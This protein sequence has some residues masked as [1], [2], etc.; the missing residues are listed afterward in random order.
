MASRAA[1]VSCS[2]NRVLPTGRA[3]LPIIAMGSAGAVRERPSFIVHTLKLSE[4]ALR[5]R[6][7]GRHH[8]TSPP[9]IPTSGSGHY[10]ALDHVAHRWRAR[11]PHTAST[12]DRRLSAR[13]LI[14]MARHAAKSIARRSAAVDAKLKKKPRGE[15][16]ARGQ[17]LGQQTSRQHD[18]SS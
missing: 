5:E 16:T 14:L 6:Q 7:W 1:A 11:L 8:E 9:A 18:A 4:R 3:E 12:L 17:S 13:R 2:I 15:G 10:R